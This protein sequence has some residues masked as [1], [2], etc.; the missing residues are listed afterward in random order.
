MGE[1]ETENSQ[2]NVN[3]T[4]VPWRRRSRNSRV[5]NSRVHCAGLG[6]RSAPPN[7]KSPTSPAIFAAFKSLYEEKRN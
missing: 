1:L 7:E 2:G 4:L 5:R 3:V 6:F